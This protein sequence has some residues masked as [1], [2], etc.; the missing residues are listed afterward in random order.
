[1]YIQFKLMIKMNLSKKKV[2]FFFDNQECP[3]QLASTST[4]PTGPE[5]SGWINL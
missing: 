4:N 1:M 3:G 5:V 2:S